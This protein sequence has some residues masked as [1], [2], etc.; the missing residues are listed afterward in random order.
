MDNYSPKSPQYSPNSPQ[1]NTSK[2]E[3]VVD[4][5]TEEE[6][7]KI[8]KSVAHHLKTAGFEV[9]FR[10]SMKYVVFF[11]PVDQGAVG[12]VTPRPEESSYCSV[13]VDGPMFMLKETRTNSGYWKKDFEL[14]SFL[15]TYDPYDESMKFFDTEESFVKCINAYRK[16]VEM[17]K[18]RDCP[19][20]ERGV[21]Y[22]DCNHPFSGVA[23][24]NL[25]QCGDSGVSTRLGRVT[26]ERS[27]D[28]KLTITLDEID[29]ES[30]NDIFDVQQI[31]MTAPAGIL[32]SQKMTK[33][34]EKKPK[35]Y[36]RR[37][38]V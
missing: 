31:D 13:T 18:T 27:E 21:P 14:Y 29:M 2:W 35:L 8:A 3:K 33:Y 26:V 23:E 20:H 11:D 28:S 16:Y 30:L 38:G 7:E 1:Y 5:H 37:R 6:R 36:L 19:G 24:I 25:V 15:D 32:K 12:Y 34:A 4:K 10:D 22:S 17:A 9:K